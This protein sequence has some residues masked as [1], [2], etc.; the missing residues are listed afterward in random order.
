MKV[1]I[2]WVQDRMRGEKL[3]IAGRD[4]YFEEFA[5]KEAEKLHELKE[6]F[7]KEKT[8]KRFAFDKRL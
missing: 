4:N 1:W 8:F 5:E 6:V 3:D 2:N 7:F